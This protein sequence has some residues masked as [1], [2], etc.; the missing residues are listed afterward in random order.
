M[1]DGTRS[2]TCPLCSRVVNI[3]NASFNKLE[4]RRVCASCSKKLN[5]VY[6]NRFSFKGVTI[7]EA[8]KAIKTYIQPN[9]TPTPAQTEPKPPKK[10]CCPKC[11]SQNIEPIGHKHKNFATGR[12]VAGSAL[13]NPVVG[14]GVGLLGKTEKKVEFYCNDCG[15]VFKR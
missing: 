10:A 8:K 9:Y 14:I 5:A 7:D 3:S 11:H 12:A 1:A 2:K 4:G 15:K 6:P 13:I